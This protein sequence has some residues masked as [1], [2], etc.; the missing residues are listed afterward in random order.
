MEENFWFRNLR[1]A[2]IKDNI[3]VLFHYAG[4][5]SSAFKDWDKDIISEFDIYSIQLPGREDRFSEKLINNMEELVTNIAGNFNFFDKH[6]VC[7]G[8]S[9][10]ALV[11]YEVIKKLEHNNLFNFRHLIVSSSRAPHI[12][13]HRNTIYNLPDEILFKTILK[14]GGIPEEL[15]SEKQMLM[16]VLLPILRAD[17]KISDL[18]ICDTN[19]KISTQ[20]T[21]FGGQEDDT[22]PEEH[23]LKWKDKTEKFEY[24]LF[25]GGHFYINESYKNLIKAINNILVS[26]LNEK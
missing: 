13:I 9:L 20:I 16:E 24:K 4:G 3:L 8:H 18:H 19:K 14:F 23:L 2:S 22:F 11:A 25:E 6:I 5:S 26:T 12:K 10:G 21:A 7:F 15:L 17:F 1:R